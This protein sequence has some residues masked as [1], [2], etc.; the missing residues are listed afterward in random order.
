MRKIPDI[1]EQIRNL[2]NILS[3]EIQKKEEEFFYKIHG[4]KVR[5]EKATKQYHKT[6]VGGIHTY[7]FNASL[8]N[9]LT[10][11]VIWFCLLPSVFLDLTVTV[12][13]A[14]C[15]PVYKIPKVRRDDYIV[16]DRHALNY[17]NAMEKLNC[18]YCGY[19]N[20]LIAYVQEI[21]ART[22]QYW[23]PI[24]HARKIGN[25]HSRYNKFLEYGDGNEYRKKIESL[26]R[27]FDDLK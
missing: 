3:L 6:L 25:I 20:G 27:D 2:E 26:R 15:F 16:I 10:A 13:Q 17:L 14:I 24:K 5:F 1:I 23:C 9:I 19:V 4:K 21:A 22:E 18:V 11:P 12:Y 8:L 7:L